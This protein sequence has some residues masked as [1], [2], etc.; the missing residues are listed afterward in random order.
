MQYVWI[1]LAGLILIGAIS[2]LFTTFLLEY[3]QRLSKKKLPTLTN[4]FVEISD[5]KIHYSIEGAG[6]TL[7]LI[8]GLGASLYIWR[9]IAKRL[10][11]NFR[12]ITIDLPGFGLSSKNPALDYGLDH[13][14]RRLIE[15]LDKLQI[16]EATLVGSS[17]GG[18]LSLWVARENPKRFRNVVVMAPAVSSSLVPRL[19]TPLQR[20]APIV[21]PILAPLFYKTLNTHT[22]KL[23]ASLVLHNRSILDEETVNAYLRPYL[24]SEESIHTFWRAIELIRDR[25]LPSELKSLS[26]R[27]LVLW[28]ERDRLVPRRVMA[29]LV[30]VLPHAEFHTHK[31]CGHHPMEDQPDWTIDEI[32]NFLRVKN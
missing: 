32:R 12:V 15:T 20:A 9:L 16:D 1:A 3:L 6:P 13:Q 26:S 25:R 24:E 17:M 30:S 18:A 14:T 8:H 11:E 31:E 2:A 19:I 27:V 5:S 21:A 23:I 22:M 4:Q 29:E 7:V 10:A 28:G